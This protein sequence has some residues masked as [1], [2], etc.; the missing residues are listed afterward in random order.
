MVQ[1]YGQ[2]WKKEKL[3]FGVTPDNDC[4]IKNGKHFN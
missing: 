4:A 1:Q 2:I 3:A